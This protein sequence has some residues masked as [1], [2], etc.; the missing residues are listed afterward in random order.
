MDNSVQLKNLT[1]RDYGYE[2]AL[3]TLRTNIQ[4]CG[5]NIKVIMLSSSVPNEGKTDIAFELASS[6]AQI[7]KKTLFIDADIRKSVI[8]SRLQPDRVVHGL[9]QYLNGQKSKSEIIYKTN[10]DNLE[11]IFSGPYS[12]NPADLLEEAGFSL[13]IEGIRMEYD[14]VI[15]DT[16]PMINLIDGAIIAPNC[17]GVVLVIESGAVSYHIIQQVKKQLEKTGCKILGLVLNKVNM[18]GNRYN[19]YYSAYGKYEKYAK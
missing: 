3:K 5:R 1:A 19:K 15:I 12:P 14:Y 17:D 18:K 6:L 2:E 8:V 7:G 16:P 4:F 13:L 10:V 11:M 9:S